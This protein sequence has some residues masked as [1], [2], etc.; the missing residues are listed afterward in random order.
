MSKFKVGDMVR[1]ISFSRIEFGN[2]L[3]VT[4]VFVDDINEYAAGNRR[5]N[6]VELELDK[7]WLREQKINKLIDGKY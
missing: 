5:Y 2:S 7:Q 3:I 4:H 6:E 1:V